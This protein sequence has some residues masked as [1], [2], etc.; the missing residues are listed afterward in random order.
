[1]SLSEGSSITSNTNGQG[2]AGSI[3]IETNAL[4][5]EKAPTQNTLP[6]YGAILSNTSR[7]GNAGDVVIY[8]RDSIFLDN[9][10][11]SSDVLDGGSRSESE[12]V[13]RWR[14]SH[15]YWI[16]Q[17]HNRSQLLAT[18]SGKAAQQSDD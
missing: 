13:A 6:V 7:Q 16:A 2:N 4:V 3:V 11:I 10:L 17:T 5:I 14:R 15:H 8:A 9:G 18:S 1:M 12:G